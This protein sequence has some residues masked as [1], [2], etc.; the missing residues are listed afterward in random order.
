MKSL[1]K[2]ISLLETFLDKGS[3]EMT[4]TELA[5]HTD[6]NISSAHGIVKVFVEKGYLIQNGKRGKYS[7]GLKLLEF[8][9]AIRKG[10]RLRDVALPFMKH[11]C[12]L[13]NESVSIAVLDKYTGTEIEVVEADQQ[14][15]VASFSGPNMPLYC[16]GLGRVLL[17]DMSEVELE[18]Y[19]E[20]VELIAY[21]PHTITD[22]EKIKQKLKVVKE[23]GYALDDQETVLGVR[24][25]AAPIRYND[26]K[27]VAALGIYGP[28]IRVTDQRVGEL[29]I[30]V[31]EYA[32]KIS[33]A[34][35]EM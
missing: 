15:G 23:K 7:L 35:G 17:A 22:F 34:M 25:L 28:S 12:G 14:L 8:S 11:L 29:I 32:K 27:C 1:R 19:V 10:L 6:M 13:I 26:G 3:R 24:N 30:A 9:N 18:D 31:K 16:T 4:L 2:S 5:E 33:M 21:T 20:H